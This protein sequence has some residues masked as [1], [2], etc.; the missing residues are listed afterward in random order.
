MIQSQT[1]VSAEEIAVLVGGML[2]V[3]KEHVK[4]RKTLEAIGIGV[5]R[6]LPAEEQKV[7]EALGL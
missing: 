7:L 4:D 1:M 5:S 6:L 3:I 2:K